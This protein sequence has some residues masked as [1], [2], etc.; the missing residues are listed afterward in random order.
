ME[1]F[2]PNTP[3]KTAK[4]KPAKKTQTWNSGLVQG[5]EI[6]SSRRPAITF[7]KVSNLQKNKKGFFKGFETMVSTPTGKK[8]PIGEIFTVA[9]M[10]KISAD[11]SEKFKNPVSLD[12]RFLGRKRSRPIRT[13]V[14]LSSG[15]TEKLKPD[16]HSIG[17]YSQGNEPDRDSQV[18][19]K[20]FNKVRDYW[21]VPFS[22][23][24]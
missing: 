2:T 5:S 17:T 19:L 13:Y 11:V 10:V 15:S 7:L 8:I 20:A 23:R 24:T 6:S 14:S 22:Y 4:S 16:S 9:Q 18:R 1:E 12:L 21:G 3:P